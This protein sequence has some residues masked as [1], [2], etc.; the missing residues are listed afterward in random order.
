MVSQT[1]ES[2]KKDGAY[3]PEH[4]TTIKCT[5]PT[6][7][8]E[9][10]KVCAAV[11]FCENNPISKTF[12]KKTEQIP[13]E[14]LPQTSEQGSVDNAIREFKQLC[15]D[16]ILF[17]YNEY[18][19]KNNLSSK[20]AVA[21][22]YAVLGKT[23][24]PLFE[25]VDDLRRTDSYYR[26]LL[27]RVVNA[28]SSGKYGEEALQ[29]YYKYMRKEMSYETFKK[30]IGIKNNKDL[31]AYEIN[32]MG[33]PDVVIGGKNNSLDPQSNGATCEI[34]FPGDPWRDGQYKK[35][36]RIA[37]NNKKKL[38][39]LNVDSC[40][41]GDSPEKHSQEFMQMAALIPVFWDEI[42]KDME[43]TAKEFA[44]QA[45]S[46]APVG[47]VIKGAQTVLD[48]VESLKYIRMIFKN[49]N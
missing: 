46:M 10:Y 27:V 30:I 31:P 34:K 3:Q 4:Q 15:V 49:M 24:I 25:T 47:K 22:P 35:Y 29:I 38:E 13:G 12:S 6:I 19:K 17:K 43:E 1:T 41:C 40:S 16:K 11:C 9:I 42:K 14:E 26:V 18:M 5:D 7:R 2:S 48:K 21:P 45:A 36:L 39:E 33:M 23:A 28:L 44:W 32:T 37:G 8:G 20:I